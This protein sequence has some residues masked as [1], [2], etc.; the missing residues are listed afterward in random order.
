[1]CNLRLGVQMHWLAPMV[2]LWQT[3]NTE[4]YI[5]SARPFVQPALVDNFDLSVIPTRSEFEEALL[6]LSSRKA[7]GYDGIGAELWK[8]DPM[9]HKPPTLSSI[10]ESGCQRLHPIAI[11]RWPVGSAVQKQRSSGRSRLLQR[12]PTTKHRRKDFCKKLAIKACPQIQP[13]CSP[14]AMWLHEAERS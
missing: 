13:L 6:M 7:P 12:H 9:C 5:Q 3:E 11:P 10:F 4:D 14:N 8:S 2:R 1:M